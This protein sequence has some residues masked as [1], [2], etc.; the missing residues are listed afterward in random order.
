MEGSR[1][2]FEWFGNGIETKIPVR[3]IAEKHISF[4]LGDS[5]AEYGKNGSVKLLTLNYAISDIQTPAHVSLV[6]GCFCIP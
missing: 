6:Y 3:E 5:G 2:L 4:T 1:Y